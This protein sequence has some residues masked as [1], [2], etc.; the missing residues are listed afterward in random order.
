[1]ENILITGANGL[2]GQKCIQTFNSHAY[3]VVGCDLH[4]NSYVRAKNLVYKQFDITNRISVKNVVEQFVP[5]AIINTAA[6]TNVD[7]SEVEK[8]KCWKINV[9][10]VEN[11]VYAAQKVGSSIIQIS[12]DYIFDGNNG[13]YTENDDPEPIGYYGKSKL[14]AE[15]VLIKSGIDHAILRT[16][17]LYGNGRNVRLNFVTWIIKKLQAGEKISV[18]T[19]QIGNPTLTDDLANVIKNV[20][21]QKKYDI[22]HAAGRDI[23]DRYNFALKIADTFKLDKSLITP[24][25]TCDLNQTAPRPLK[26]GFILSKLEQELGIETM[27][28]EESLKLFKKQYKLN[29][30]KLIGRR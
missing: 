27:S 19:D 9:E 4:E 7:A 10:G 24:I 6:F 11:L 25:K 15:N 30:L 8:E 16:M 29:H 17:V 13:P 2:L 21:E 26:S 18:V 5:N 23:V 14:A 1:M 12:T 22:F 28:I 20:Y 3:R